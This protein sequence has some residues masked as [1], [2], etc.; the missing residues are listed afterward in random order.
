[1]KAFAEL[2]G[3]LVEGAL[4]HPSA[5]AEWFL[6][7]V[8][9]LKAQLVVSTAGPESHYPPLE[10][11]REVRLKA[12]G[13]VLAQAVQAGLELTAQPDQ[14]RAVRLDTLKCTVAPQLM[15]DGNVPE[16]ESAVIAQ[17]EPAQPPET[18]G[19]KASPFEMQTVYVVQEGTAEGVVAQTP[20]SAPD[21][22][23][24]TSQPM[25]FKSAGP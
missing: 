14:R 13:N 8:A 19:P 20:A 2:L 22:V 3:H 18:S 25:L 6:A 7:E 12:L 4:R 17:V 16:P 21:L 15:Y 9:E 11:L 24:R 5:D 1:M 23:A 10:T